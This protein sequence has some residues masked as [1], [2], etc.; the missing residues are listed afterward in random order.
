MKKKEN[1]Q[2][3]S[4]AIPSLGIEIENNAEKQKVV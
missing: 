3:V 1:L 2:P 4:V